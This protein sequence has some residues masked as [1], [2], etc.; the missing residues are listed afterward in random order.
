MYDCECSTSNYEQP[1]LQTNTAG[2]DTG[3]GFSQ[4]S[5]MLPFQQAAVQSYLSSGV[6]LPLS[7]LFNPSNRA[8]P[9]IG[10]VGEDFCCLDPGGSC[11]LLSGTSASTPLIAGM[12]TLLNQDRLNAGKTPLGFFAPVI[13]KMFGSGSQYFNSNF[14]GGNNSGEC[15]STHGFVAAQG[16]NPLVGCG[17]PKFPAIREFVASLQ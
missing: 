10:A 7:F 8:F 4:F 14:T 12:I 2:F 13:Y 5:A 11:F 1:A 3:G 17:S 6:K 16:W 9:D 15:P